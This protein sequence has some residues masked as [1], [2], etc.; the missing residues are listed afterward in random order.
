MVIPVAI[1]VA[2]WLWA[3]GSDVSS[4]SQITLSD[5]LLFPSWAY[6]SLSSMLGALAG[7]DYSFA[8]STFEAGPTL[9][10]LALIGVGW[11]FQRGP[12]PK[13]VWAAL[14]IALSF[15]LMGA[16]SKDLT[17]NAGQ[18]RYLYPGALVV[19]IAGAWLAAGMGWRRSALVAL[20]LVAATGVVTNLAL[21]R[22]DGALNRFET[23][24]QRA[25]LA[26]IEVAG[27]N[28]D[29]SYIPESG[30]QEIRF[31]LG[32]T[33]YRRGLPQRSRTLRVD[34]VLAARRSAG[35]SSRSECSPTRTWSLRWD[36]P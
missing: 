3:L 29:P 2:W 19:L 15:W 26:G 13:M 17:P 30:P 11:R 7:L 14:A 24:Q 27:A 35:S 8:G 4:E 22:D 28:A 33:R 6:Q 10:V 9:A 32:S 36:W 1:Y 25:I 16:V 20:F 31:S 34:R 21:L 12:V 5:V 18:S 23:A